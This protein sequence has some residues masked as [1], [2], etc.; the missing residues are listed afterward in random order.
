MLCK[1]VFSCLIL[2]AGLSMISCQ[3]VNTNRISKYLFSIAHKLLVLC[4]DRFVLKFMSHWDLAYKTLNHLIIPAYKR[5]TS[6]IFAYSVHSWNI[7]ERKVEIGFPLMPK[8]N[9]ANNLSPRNKT[10]Y[11]PLSLRAI[12]RNLF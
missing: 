7:T 10:I 4:S 5:N 8:K 9:Y 1:K 12:N 3:V 11:T 2:F 6:L